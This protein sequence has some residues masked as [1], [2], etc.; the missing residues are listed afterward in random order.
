MAKSERAIRVGL[1][2][3]LGLHSD[4]VEG[5]LLPWIV[6]HAV[7]QINRYLV[8]SDGR[9]SFEKVFNQPQRSPTVHFGE[10]VPA[11]IQSQPLL[12]IADQVSTSEVIWIMFGKGSCHRWSDPQ[13]ENDHALGERKS[14]QCRRTQ[15]VQGSYSRIFLWS[16]LVQRS[17]SKILASAKELCQV[18]V[19]RIRLSGGSFFRSS[20][21]ISGFISRGSDFSI[22]SKTFRVIYPSCS[23]SASPRTTSTSANQKKS[24]WKASP[25]RVRDQRDQI[26]QA[27]NL[28]NQWEVSQ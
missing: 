7:Y 25:I 22:S 10:R 2:D 16:D 8:R 9:T 27:K 28:W 1:A 15:E 4:Q 18:W 14:V 26:S 11:H 21:W 17:R 6:Q 13:D 23:D 12:K 20:S 19:S 24:H 5:S 3:Q